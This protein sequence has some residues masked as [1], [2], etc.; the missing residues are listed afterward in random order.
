M[1]WGLLSQLVGGHQPGDPLHPFSSCFPPQNPSD[2]PLCPR[3]CRQGPASLFSRQ[4]QHFQAWF[5]LIPTP[6]LTTSHLLSLFLSFLMSL[7]IKLHFEHTV[8]KF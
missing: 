8:V 5:S 3:Q 4:Q 1:S 2:E 6:F 7:S